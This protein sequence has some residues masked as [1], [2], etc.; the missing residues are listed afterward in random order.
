MPSGRPPFPLLILLHGLGD[1]SLTPCRM[2]ARSL[3]EKNIACFLLYL[4]YH[5]RRNPEELKKAKVLY[6]T[7]AQWLEPFEV[8]IAD[9]R[10]VIDWSELRT[11]LDSQHIAIMGISIGGFVAAIAMGVEKRI[12]AGVLMLT[13]GNLE[14]ITWESK[15]P[16]I[17]RIHGGSDYVER[18][19]LCHQIYSQYPHYLDEVKKKGFDNVTPPKECFLFDPMTFAHCLRD[20]PLL[21]INALWDSII[22]K[23]SLL[24]F[25]E[26]CGKPPTLWLPCTHLTL[27]AWYPI[28]QRK[29]SCFCQQAYTT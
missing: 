21:L 4:P 27:L 9:V 20:R 22:P 25:G 29:L 8:S 19:E 1:L 28:I 10:T 14:R 16:S 13:G 18:R 17:R 23:R 11:E 7:A 2:L 6:L 15:S 3:V 5:S 12:S 26:A 24:E